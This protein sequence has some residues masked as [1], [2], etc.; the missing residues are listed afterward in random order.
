MR[1]AAH[2]LLGLVLL[3]ACSKRAPAPD[4]G[5][6][7]EPAPVKPGRT[8]D[9]RLRDFAETKTVFAGLYPKWCR[10]KRAEEK[11][12][13]VHDTARSYNAALMSLKALEKVA[14]EEASPSP[15][16]VSAPCASKVN[17]ELVAFLTNS[18]AVLSRVRTCIEAHRAEIERGL[19]T[20]TFSQAK[21]SEC[22][23]FLPTF[24]NGMNCV[25]ELMLCGRK[26]C[27]FYD[28]AAGLGLACDPKE[29]ADEEPRF[30][31]QR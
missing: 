31:E 14:N 21:P 27:E 10:V 4:A 25:R 18:P 12:D 7:V 28:V 17:N 22:T 5:K 26:P 8:R 19:H 13:Q 24:T 30:A 15:V 1:L 20:D 9:D 6:V 16:V 2:V 23:E 3:S 11:W 29:N